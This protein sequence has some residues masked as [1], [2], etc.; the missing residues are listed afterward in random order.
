MPRTPLRLLLLI[1][2]RVLL[3]LL[4]L[5]LQT[6]LYQTLPSAKGHATLYGL[7]TVAACVAAAD[8]HQCCC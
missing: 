7:A 6:H 1:W 8:P 5:L 2:L 4:L 3:P